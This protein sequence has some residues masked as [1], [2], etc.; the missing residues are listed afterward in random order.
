VTRDQLLNHLYEMNA[1]RISNVVA[2]QVRLLRRKLSEH[3]CDDLIETV[4]GM[5]YRFN[6]TYAD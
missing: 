5:G 1:E 4:P 2:A 3:G 6:P